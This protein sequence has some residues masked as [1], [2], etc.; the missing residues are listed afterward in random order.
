MSFFDDHYQTPRWYQKKMSRRTALKAAAGASLI[1]G[2]PK[3]LAKVQSEN[4][5]AQFEQMLRTDP[6]QTLD[7]VLQQLL[8]ESESGPSAKAIQATEYLYNVVQYQPID[9][10]EKVFIVKGVTWLNGYSQSELKRSFVDLSPAEKQQVLKSISGSQA[11]HNWINTLLNYIFEA[12]LS[13]PAYGGNPNGIGW[14]WLEHQPGFPLP[15]Q[16]SRYYELLGSYK[17]SAKSQLVEDKTK[18]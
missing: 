11:G 5:K 8:P 1:G 6:W 13:P 15:N 12:M 3:A 9:P 16:G 17:S 18:S 2:L 14:Q 10:D 4:D 7:A